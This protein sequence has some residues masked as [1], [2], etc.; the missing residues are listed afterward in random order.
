MDSRFGTIHHLAT[1]G[2]VWDQSMAS[3]FIP[4]LISLAGFYGISFAFPALMLY[5][6][7]V[8]AR[9]GRLSHPA[10]QV[11]VSLGCGMEEHR[12]VMKGVTG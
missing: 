3:L 9:G 11:Q 10:A 8:M 1:T 2:R 7:R 5:Q 12:S 4:S 6:S